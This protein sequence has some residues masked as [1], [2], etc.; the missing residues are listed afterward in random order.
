MTSLPKIEEFIRK[1][2]KASE[3]LVRVVLRQQ[4]RYE[5]DFRASSIPRSLRRELRM[6]MYLQNGVSRYYD[7]LRR[8][9]PPALTRTNRSQRL[10]M[11]LAEFE[12]L[13]EKLTYNNFALAY[14][15]VKEGRVHNPI[16]T[17]EDKKIYSL[18][19]LYLGKIT[20]DQFKKEFG[21]CALNAYELSEKRFSE[22]TPQELK[23]LG[24]FAPNLQPESKMPLEKY[25]ASPIRKKVPILIALRE[26]AKYNTLFLVRD[27]RY[28]ILEIAKHNGENRIFDKSYEE[29]TALEA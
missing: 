10:K 9:S 5:N 18:K 24:K 8:Y 19:Q 14:I 29:I 3:S 2:S 15:Y 11:L 25:F 4:A 6:Q 13:Y 16:Y 1:P 20:P 27:M 21:H 12:T 23:A 26:L 17:I 28:T 22:Y 7:S